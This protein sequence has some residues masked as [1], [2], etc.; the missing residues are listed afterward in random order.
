MAG[1]RGASA[2][3]GGADGRPLIEVNADD[4][5]AVLAALR[6][7]LFADGPAVLPRRGASGAAKAGVVPADTC[8]VIET[9][10]STAVPK[11]VMLTREGL[12]AS[13][14]A[15]ATRLGGGKTPREAD[16]QWLLAL[17]VDY[18]A[19]AQVLVRSLIAGT[20]PA[21]LPLDASFTPERFLT[22]AAQMTAPRRFTSLVPAQLIRLVD[23][24]ESPEASEVPAPAEAPAQTS[25]QTPAPASGLA[26]EVRAAVARFDAVLVGGQ[27]TPASVRERARALGWRIVTTYGASETSGGCVYDGIPLPGVSVRECDGEVQISGPVLA[28]GYLGDPERTA[29]RFITDGSRR[30]YRTGDAGRVCEPAGAASSEDGLGAGAARDAGLRAPRV[31]I[32]GRLDDVIISGGEKVMLGAVERCV[33]DVS[34]CERAVVV[35]AA[36]ETWGEVPVVALERPDV[37]AAVAS[38]KVPIPAEIHAEANGANE[39]DAEQLLHSLRIACGEALGRAARPAH[40]HIL[41]AIPRLSSGKPDRRALEREIA[42][43]CAVLGG[44]TP[45]REHEVRGDPEPPKTRG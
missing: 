22:A 27:A 6:E 38:G 16:G 44:Q 7:A 37:T 26:Q 9:S 19:G 12:L 30:W 31:D 23:A 29:D 32:T 15:S 24:A 34:G 17:P 36:S 13:A 41:P 21:V 28:A 45:A 25:A 5:R 10:G 1:G 35:R 4:P 43:E 33:R 11:R 42:G 40:L 20:E 39:D 2:A 3:R 18:V 8:L 14:R